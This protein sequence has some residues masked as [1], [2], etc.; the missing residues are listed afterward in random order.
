MS[1]KYAD[2]SKAM[3]FKRAIQPDQR[4]FCLASI[5][6]NPRLNAQ[7]YKNIRNFI[8]SIL[9]EGDTGLLGGNQG[10]NYHKDLVP[11]MA[12]RLNEIQARILELCLVGNVRRDMNLF[13]NAYDIV[14][15][16]LEIEESRI[17]CEQVFNHN[18]PPKD[19]FVPTVI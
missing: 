9:R 4:I 19:I 13:R 10:Y 5:L 1:N 7:G 8:S 16:I 2:P 15:W 18:K 6:V 3:A 14:S 12:G 17:M 11:F